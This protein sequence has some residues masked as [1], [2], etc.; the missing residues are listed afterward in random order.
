MEVKWDK[1]VI[2]NKHFEVKQSHGFSKKHNM[3]QQN[4]SWKRGLQETLAQLGNYG[5]L[6]C[7]FN[8]RNIKTSKFLC[9]YVLQEFNNVFRGFSYCYFKVVTHAR[10]EYS[11]KKITLYIRNTK[12]T[13]ALAKKLDEVYSGPVLSFLDVHICPSTQFQFTRRSL[14]LLVN[15]SG[16]VD[17][18]SEVS[19]FYV[20]RFHCQAKFDCNDK[21][22]I[23]TEVT[24]YKS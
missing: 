4:E 3:V 2:F 12:Y 7:A 17:Q 18:L 15:I 14:N 11:F 6:T 19:P 1:F 20:H 16:W 9:T 10:Q 8:V 22:R 5:T 23:S 21:Q 24:D 13:H